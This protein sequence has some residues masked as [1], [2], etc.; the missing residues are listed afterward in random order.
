MPEILTE[1]NE[2]NEVAESVLDQY[3]AVEDGE[4]F[5]LKS[6]VP[7]RTALREANR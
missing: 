2:L 7:L 3:V 4:G 5:I 1:V 6:A